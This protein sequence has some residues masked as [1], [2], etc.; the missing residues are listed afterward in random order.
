MTRSAQEGPEKT[1]ALLRVSNAFA[2]IFWGLLAWALMWIGVVQVPM[3][4][5]WGIPAS[6]VSGVLW[7]TAAWLLATTTPLT[8]RWPAAARGFALMIGLHLYLLPYLGWWQ[9][10]APAPYRHFNTA[11]LVCAI[12][13]GIFQLHRLASE[14]ARALHDRVLFTEG[15]LSFWSIPVIAFIFLGVFVWSAHRIGLDLGWRDWLDYF[16]SQRPWSLRTTALLFL[17]PLLP[18]MA[19]AW[20]VR[21]RIHAWLPRGRCPEEEA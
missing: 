9:W 15:R 18:P 17:M 10:T 4:A 5:R 6:A 1:A 12:A 8:P 16:A 21:Q 14:I 11:L 3:L 20:E 13:G 19:L 7:A 2:L